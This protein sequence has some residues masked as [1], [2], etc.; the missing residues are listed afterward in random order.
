MLS[1]LYATKLN[2]T[3][4]WD[5]NGRRLPVS[6]VSCPSMVITQIKKT[7][8][9]GYSA[10]QIGFGQQ[11]TQ[12][13]KKP[14]IGHL[15]PLKSKQYPRDLKEIRV[16]ADSQFNLG[17]Q[18]TPSQI[19]KAGDRVKVT[20]KSF[21][22]GFAGVIKRWG[23]GGGPRSHGQSDRRRA[24]G[25]IGQG[26]D[27]GRVWKGKKMAGRYGNQ[28]FTIKNLT[29]IKVQDDQIWIKGTIPGKI[30]SLIKITKTGDTN[31]PGLISDLPTTDNLEK[32]D[33][34]DTTKPKEELQDNKSDRQPSQ[35][36]E[37][38][39][40]TEKENKDQLPKEPDKK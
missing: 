34:S 38:K 40:S 36:S 23:F 12:R 8:K 14:T 33:K 1:S 25:S 32:S 24:P 37:S 27:P 19:L 15:K 2:M 18:L 30:G 10:I 4:A 29:I 16:K 31:F 21:G 3:Q 28:Q 26:T 13:L 7:D 11:K 35:E 39:G 9:D 17:D 20:G 5:K 6:I 22:R